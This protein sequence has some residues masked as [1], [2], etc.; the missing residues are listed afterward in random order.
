MDQTCHCGKDGHAFNSVNCPIHGERVAHKV[1]TAE[2]YAA[3]PIVGW[4]EVCR[5]IDGFGG[6]GIRYKGLSRS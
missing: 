6:V 2:E 3:T 4:H 5:D 1:M